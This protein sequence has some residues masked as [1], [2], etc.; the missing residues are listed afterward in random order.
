M[1]AYIKFVL[2]I[3]GQTGTIE[4]DYD[5]FIGFNSSVYTVSEDDGFV[6]LTIVKNASTTENI[7]VLFFTS[8]GTAQG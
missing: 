1:H 6:D 7:T 3:G 5:G 8:N 2:H 4:I